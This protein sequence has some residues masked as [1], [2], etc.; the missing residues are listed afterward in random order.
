MSEKTR[1]QIYRADL[2]T[3]HYSFHAYGISPEHA[4]EILEG[5]WMEHV[6]QTGA[7]KDFL[8]QFA[9][10]I[11][12]EACVPGVGLRDGDQLYPQEVDSSRPRLR[13]GPGRR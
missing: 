8:E 7:D 11:H 10:D 2:E 1:A 9:D 3:R 12:V 6:K 4:K 5:T 13:P